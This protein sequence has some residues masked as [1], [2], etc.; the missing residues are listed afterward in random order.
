[1]RRWC[2]ASGVSAGEFV[3]IKQLKT[4]AMDDKALTAFEV[5]RPNVNVSVRAPCGSC[6]VKFNAPSTQA[7]I[8]LLERL[9]HPNVVRYLNVMRTT[10]HLNL[11]IECA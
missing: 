11:V 6:V 2:G 8:Q 4:R 5:S 7:E 9:N 1:M 3:A 10:E